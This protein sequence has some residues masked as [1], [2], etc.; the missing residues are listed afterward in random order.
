MPNF[1]F[2]LGSTPELSFKELELILP[3][4]QLDRLLI[5]LVKINLPD[6]QTANQ[7]IKILG[8]TVKILQ[9]RSILDPGCHQDQIVTRLAEL[10]A[11]QHPHTFAIAEWGRDHLPKIEPAEIK[12]L[13]R[14]RGLNLSYKEQTRH[15]LSAS[16][17]LHHPDIFELVV[18]QTQTQTIIAQSVA[19][20]NIDE[21]TKRD[22]SKPYFDRKKGMLPPKVARMMVNLALG[23]QALTNQLVQTAIYDPFCGS[24]TI[25]LEALMLGWPVIGSDIDPEAVRGTQKNIAWLKQAYQLSPSLTTHVFIQDATHVQISDFSHPIQYLVAEPFLGKPTPRETEVANIFK[26]LEK[27]YLGMFKRWQ[28]IFA[29]G[30]EI[31][32]VM[33]LVETSKHTYNLEG[34]IDKLANLGY[35]TVFKPI[36]YKRPQAIVQRQI[37]K[38]K[39]H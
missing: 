6:I 39:Y 17:L 16:L 10:I 13:I 24:G 34:L 4:S 28:S 29:A 8:G 22:R 19:V 38:F 7:L 30:A 12:N 11:D 25:L 36:V 21:W 20:Q 14:D 26:G 37:V 33:P 18:I 15:G 5:D 23:E 3:Q 27:L 32:L 2:Q 1:Y 9:E 35:T 31:V